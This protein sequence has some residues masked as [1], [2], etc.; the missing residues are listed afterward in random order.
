MAQ[1]VYFVPLIIRKKR[2][3]YRINVLFFALR[4]ISYDYSKLYFCPIRHF[5]RFAINNT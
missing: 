2:E 3:I 4:F 1:M 5:A